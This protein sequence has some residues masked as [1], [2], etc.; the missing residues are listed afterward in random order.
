MPQTCVAARQ[1]E[2]AY[3]SCFAHTLHF[4][5]E[6]CLKIAPVAKG[7][8]KADSLTAGSQFELTLHQ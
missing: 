6:E 5:I 7:L 4:A 8:G 3:T 1:M 2:V